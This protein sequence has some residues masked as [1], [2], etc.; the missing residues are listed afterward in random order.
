MVTIQFLDKIFFRKNS[1]VPPSPLIP[2]LSIVLI[3]ALIYVTVS[4]TIM[5]LARSLSSLII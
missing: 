2:Q 5:S 1:K 4:H 3:T